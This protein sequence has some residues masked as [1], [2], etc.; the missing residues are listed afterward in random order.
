MPHLPS[1]SLLSLGSVKYSSSDRCGSFEA[2]PLS[3]PLSLALSPPLWEEVGGASMAAR[4]LDWAWSCAAPRKSCRGLIL[5][6]FFF[7]VS[8][9]CSTRVFVTMSNPVAV[10]TYDISKKRLTIAS[11]N[12]YCTVLLSHSINGKVQCHVGR[13]CGA[14]VQYGCYQHRHK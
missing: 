3:A 7:S 10:N 6:C 1:Y 9:K 11:L 14:L 2:P 12:Y 13:F 4:L 5:L 8:G